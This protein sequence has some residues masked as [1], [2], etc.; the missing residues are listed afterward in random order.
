MEKKQIKKILK[1]Q[2]ILGYINIFIA[3]VII[4]SLI[5]W[6]VTGSAFGFVFLFF[7]LIMLL[8]TYLQSEKEK[9]IFVEIYKV[10]SYSQVKALELVNR[11][12]KYCEESK[13]VYGG[14]T[15]GIDFNTS[16]INNKVRTTGVTNPRMRAHSKSLMKNQIYSRRKNNNKGLEKKIEILI[17]LK[18]LLESITIPQSAWDI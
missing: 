12:L 11:N 14:D 9:N 15:K 16:I 13:N 1:K 10:N 4:T 17:R 5:I 7:F 18:G 8:G 6:G 3:V 2:I